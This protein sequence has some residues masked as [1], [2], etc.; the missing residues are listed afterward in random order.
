M[1]FSKYVWKNNQLEKKAKQYD[2][3]TLG[4]MAGVLLVFFFAPGQVKLLNIP[5]IVVGMV[6]TYLSYRI[7]MQDRKIQTA[8][9]R[10]VRIVK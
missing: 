9:K 4:V 8:D 6:L 5:L 3:I 1:A 10:P 2:N 7:K